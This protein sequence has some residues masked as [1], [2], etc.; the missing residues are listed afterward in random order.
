MP[1]NILFVSYTVICCEF[2]GNFMAMQNPLA[3]GTDYVAALLNALEKIP[4]VYSKPPSSGGA[5]ISVRFTAGRLAL[6]DALVKQSGWT[7]SDIIN[8][9]VDRG[10]FELFDQMSHSTAN[11]ILTGIS[12]NVVP[13]FDTYPNMENLMN[14]R[15]QEIADQVLVDMA[16]MNM[17]AGTM[18]PFKT[19]W[20]RILKV[21]GITTNE[22]EKSIDWAVNVMCYLTF[23]PGGISGL[24]SIALTE[25]G[26]QRSRAL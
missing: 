25:E 19:I 1:C 15:N 5:Q 21:G 3:G 12:Q 6:L 14:N 13:K 4:N 20:L 16:S 17:G 26:Y 18:M 23:T 2:F 11:Q 8:A 9:T 24:G 7:R 10:L 22:L